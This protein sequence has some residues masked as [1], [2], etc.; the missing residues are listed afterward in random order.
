MRFWIECTRFETGQPYHVNI[1]LVG[2]M[3]RDGERTILGLRR[4]RRAEGRGEGNAGTDPAHASRPGRDGAMTAMPDNAEAASADLR[5]VGAHPDYWYP[6][7]WSRELK[8]GKTFAAS[9]AGEPIVL[10]RPIDGPVFALEDRCAHRQ[11]PL[12]KGVVDGCSIR[13][14]Y[15]GWRYD[16]F[17]P[18]H[19]RALSRQGQTAERGAVL[20]L[21]RA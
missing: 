20:S 11:V 16:E 1:S 19:R 7:A 6:A 17:R 9:F 3:W 13:C 21:L 15:H 8:A 18:L 5:S 12:S 2:G 14:C 4:Q 10:A